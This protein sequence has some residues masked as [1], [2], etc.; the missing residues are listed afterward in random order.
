MT[1]SG[2]TTSLDTW[3]WGVRKTKSARLER[4][5]RQS[6]SAGRVSVLRRWGPGVSARKVVVVVRRRRGSSAGLWEIARSVQV[7]ETASV[8]NVT[9]TLAG[10]GNTAP[11][12]SPTL[13]AEITVN[14]TVSRARLSVAVRTAGRQIV[15][16]DLASAP[17]LLQRTTTTA[18]RPGEMIRETFNTQNAVELTR[19]PASVTSATART[20]SLVSTA[21]WTHASAP[22]REPVTAWRP[23]FSVIFTATT[24]PFLRSIE[25]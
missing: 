16:L 6:I 10:W 7:T 4:T 12:T 2:A 20:A 5:K 9:V 15:L 8:E 13:T 14:T 19:G 3:A 22:R 17:V 18:G 23:A 24:S 25:R 21:R 1:A 11:A